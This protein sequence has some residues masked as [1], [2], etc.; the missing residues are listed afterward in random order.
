VFKIAIQITV[1]YM[2]HF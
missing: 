1:K 2:S